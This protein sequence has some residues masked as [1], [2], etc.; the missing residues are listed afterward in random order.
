MPE[1]EK[2]FHYRNVDV[3]S[4]K[5]V[6]YRWFPKADKIQKKS[7]HLAL[8]DVYDSISELQYYKKYFISYNK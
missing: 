4:F 7:Q 5:E 1:L 3:S 8:S 2:Y 6:L